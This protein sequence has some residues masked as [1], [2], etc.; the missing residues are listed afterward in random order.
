MWYFVTAATGTEYTHCHGDT[1]LDSN[2]EAKNKPL[3]IFRGTALPLASERSRAEVGPGHELPPGPTE[4]PSKVFRQS[5]VFGK[6]V[7]WTILFQIGLKRKCNHHQ[8]RL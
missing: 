1:E 5:L 3:G 6:V 8:L 7:N 4:G 2:N